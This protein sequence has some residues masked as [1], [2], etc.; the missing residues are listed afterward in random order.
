MFKIKRINQ[1]FFIENNK[2]IESMKQDKI[3]YVCMLVSMLF[4]HMY[5]SSFSV[6]P[7]FKVCL[8]LKSISYS[9]VPINCL[10]KS[11][12]NYGNYFNTHTVGTE[13]LKVR[14]LWKN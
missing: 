12:K 4:V 10:H 3:F 5:L 9:F 7:F 1:G 14:F 13:V 11:L 2:K 8:N 6:P